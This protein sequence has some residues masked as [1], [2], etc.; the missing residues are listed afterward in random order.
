LYIINRRDSD[1]TSQEIHLP[2]S[3]EQ[4]YTSVT[5]L[6]EIAF[7]FVVRSQSVQLLNPETRRAIHTFKT[8]PIQ[9]RTFKCSVSQPRR[10]PC[11]SMGVTSLTISYNNTYTRDLEVQTFVAQYDGDSICLCDPALPRS[12]SCLRWETSKELKRIITSPGTWEALPSGLL[13]GVRRKPSEQVGHNGHSHLPLEGLRKR[14][15]SLNQQAIKSGLR[16][17][18][19]WEAWMFSHFGKHETWETVPLCPDTEDDGHLFATN[20]GPMARI[21]RS[22]IAVGLS[23]VVKVIMVGHDRFEAGETVSLGNGVPAASSRRRRGPPS[24]RSRPSVLNLS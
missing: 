9:P 21:G 20:V 12:K 13:V 7:F 1:W 3:K 16:G 24:S 17:Q 5:A 15:R 2:G 11:S 19:D 6:P 23:N 10:L 14:R 22:S 4:E 8:G 18:E